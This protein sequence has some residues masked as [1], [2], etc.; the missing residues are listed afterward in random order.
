MISGIFRSS[1]LVFLVL[2]AN[3]LLLAQNKTTNYD[4]ELKIG[5]VNL[6]ENLSEFL[7]T[8]QHENE[9]WIEGNIYRIIQFYNIP[10]QELKNKM[11]HSGLVF[12]DYIPNKAYVVSIPYGFDINLLKAFN[13]RS[14][15]GIIPEYKQNPLILDRNYPE[16]ALAGNNEIKIIVSYYS[17]LDFNTAGSYIEPY[18]ISIIQNDK[19]AHSQIVKVKL[20]DLDAIITTNAVSFVEPIYPDGEPENYTGKTQHRS[21]VLDSQYP[22]GRHYDG[23]DVHVM[24]QDDGYIGPHA[25]YE[26][27]IGEQ[28]IEYNGGDHGDHCA[29]IIFGAGNINPTTTG[30]APGATLYTYGAAPEYP[31]FNLIPSHY[32]LNNIRITS[33]SYSNG[34]N[35]GYTTLARTMDIQIRT[36]QSLIHVFSAGNDGTSNCG[37]GA[38]A[39]WGNITGGHKVGKNVVAVANLS[40]NDNLAGSSSRGPAHDGR[41]KPDISA[42]GSDVYST[43][44]PNTYAI[45]SGTSMSCP[46]VS[47]SLAQLYQAFKELNGGTEPPGGL[48]KGLILNTADDLGNVGPDF[49]YG[50]GRINNLKAV[51]TLE[52]NRFLIDEISQ[53][54]TNNHSIIVPAGVKELKVMVYWTDKEASVGT[55]KALVNDMD[56]IISDPSSNMYLPWLLSSYPNPDSLNKPA[57]K[58]ADHLNNVEQVSILNPIGGNYTLDVTGFEITFGPQEYY[59]FYEFLY[60]EVVVTYPIGG[61]SFP[62]GQAITVRWDAIGDTDPFTFEYSLDNGANWMLVSSNINADQRYYNWNAPSEISGSALIRISRNGMSGTSEETFSVMGVP[63][64]LWVDRSCPNS[65]L[66]RWDALENAISYDVYQLGEKYMEIVASTTADSLEIDGLNYE[67]TYWFSVRAIGPG[68]AIGRR[69]I[70][71]EKQPGVWNCLFSKDLELSDIISPP[72]G[73]LFDCQDYS[74]IPVRIEITNRGQESM[75]NITAYYQFEN[76]A[77]ISESI[78]GPIL[79]GQKIIHEFG[80]SISL[81]TTSFYALQAWIETSDDENSSNDL[82]VGDCKLKTSQSFNLNTTM[83]FDEFNSVGFTPDCEITTCYINSKW[84]NLQ[85]TMNDDIDWRLLNGITP[86]GNTG[87]IGDHTTGTVSGK[88]LYLEATGDC[89]NQKAILNSPCFDLN[90]LT[91]PGMLF[92]FN[93]YGADMGSLHIDVISDGQLFKDVVDPLVG[94]FGAGWHEG[95]AYFQQFAGKIINIRFRGYTG[96]G[97]LS[98]LAIDDIMVTEMTGINNSEQENIRVFPNPST[99]IYN[100]SVGKNENSLI[101]LKVM[102]LMGREIL[103]KDFSAVSKNEIIN[104]QLDLSQFNNGTYLLIIQTKRN[105]YIKKLMK[106]R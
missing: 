106:F 39:G 15:T 28:Y 71:E 88:F 46:A 83:T 3:I 47:G 24:L 25:D 35:A 45:K 34:C 51:E 67:E 19:L 2:T 73:V 57:T 31:G 92:W 76:G 6:Q 78:P 97:E 102:D 100:L 101:S 62:I 95:H 74:N 59:V 65:V 21:N 85:N 81:P 44:D 37:Y 33:T 29:G 56:I 54:E 69:V 75:N 55:N 80:S 68:N 50:W 77:Q 23:T 13:I 64:S 41:I 79:P 42:K 93:M 84:F 36:Y 105:N 90:T 9:Q 103:V 99:G 11:E 20:D 94:D 27:R 49:K 48:M 91:N 10:S 104:Y 14:V 52:E 4:L 32:D 87:P 89:Y 63:Q 1:A 86:T 7:S 26:G 66:L 30:Q 38:G 18:L 5:P 82:L 96:N 17:N 70:A 98:D 58:G 22:S 60:D 12:L 40:Y 8:F 43:I 16:F 72:L 53:E 61:E